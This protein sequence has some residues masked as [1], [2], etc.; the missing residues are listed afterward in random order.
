MHLGGI[1]IIAV[2]PLSW[3]V[4]IGIWLLLGMS[5]YRS[6]RLHARRNSPKAVAALEMD[7]EGVVALRFAG[8]E[9]WQD[10]RIKT[11]FVHPWLTLLTLRVGARKTPV[12]L[13]IA[14]DAVE[15]EAFRR[16]RV[17]LNL[18]MAAA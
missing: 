12:S 7:S 11:W 16:W 4:R 9:V 18:R 6:L 5:L 2:L 8:S 14:A 15:A 1:L 10:A 17:R 13:V 3:P